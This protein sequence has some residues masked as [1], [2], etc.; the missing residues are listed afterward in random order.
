MSRRTDRARDVQCRTRM[1]P[2][3]HEACRDLLVVVEA[4]RRAE[5]SFVSRGRG[6]SFA[7]LHVRAEAIASMTH[8]LATDAKPMQ[9]YWATVLGRSIDDFLEDAACRAHSALF[10]SLDDLHGRRRPEQ[11]AWAAAVVLARITEALGH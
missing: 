10:E 1:E 3:S 2:V 4:Y 11:V 8:A 9:G 6:L 7:N 5:R